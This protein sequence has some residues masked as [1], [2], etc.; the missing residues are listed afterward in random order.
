MLIEIFTHKNIFSLFDLD[1]VSYNHMPIVIHDEKLL[2][3]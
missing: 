1:F 2:T 3:V